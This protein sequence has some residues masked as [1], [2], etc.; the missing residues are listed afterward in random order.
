MLVRALVKETGDPSISWGCDY[1]A[2]P[3]LEKHPIRVAVINEAKSQH[4]LAM[5]KWY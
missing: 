5:L 4:Q 2:E 1:Q 3:E